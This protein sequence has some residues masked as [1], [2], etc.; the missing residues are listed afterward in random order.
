MVGFGTPSV[1]N[2][3][4]V[5]NSIWDIPN[6][7]RNIIKFRTWIFPNRKVGFG[8][9]EIEMSIWECPK[10]DSEQMRVWATT[11]IR[12]NDIYKIILVIY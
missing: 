2:P 9:S 8:K 6:Q 4:L 12:L 1:P 10:S 11:E 5:P 7:I 3:Q